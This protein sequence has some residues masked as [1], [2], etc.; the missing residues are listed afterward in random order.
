VTDRFQISRRVLRGA[1]RLAANL[2]G[3]AIIR[4]SCGGRTA[5]LAVRWTAVRSDLPEPPTPG[6]SS[7]PDPVSLRVDGGLASFE[8]SSVDDLD[9]G[10]V[11][12]WDWDFG[13]PASGASN[14]ASGPRVTHRYSTTG[15]FTVTLTVT[16][17]LGLEASVS[18]V[19]SVAP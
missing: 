19:V 1:R 2:S 13:D 7:A 4:G 8:D 11:V 6:F 17:D 18:D 16:D 3:D 10:S 14:T 5:R 9:G 15:T 12:A